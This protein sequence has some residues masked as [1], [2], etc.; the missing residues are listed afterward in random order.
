[1]PPNK[2]CYRKYKSFYKIRTLKDVS[3]LPEKTNYTEWENQFLRVLNK[4]APLKLKVIRGNNKPFV[5]ITLGIPITRRSALKKN[6]NTLNNSLS[7]PNYKLRNFVVNLSQKFKKDYFQKHVSH[8]SQS[9]TFGNFA[10][11]SL[12]IK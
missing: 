10:N 4:N 8:S 11:L 9:K 6:A 1:M 2:L 5:I 7:I 3:D 12:L